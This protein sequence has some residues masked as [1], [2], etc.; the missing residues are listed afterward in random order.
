MPAQEV[1]RWRAF[2]RI[3]PFGPWRDNYHAAQIAYILACAH[4]DPKKPAPRF[5]EFMYRDPEAAR[6]AKE[7]ETVAFFDMRSK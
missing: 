3:Q 1:E 4:R 6:R 5:H 2:Y 7:Q